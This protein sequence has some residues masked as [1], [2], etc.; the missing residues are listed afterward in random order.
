[1]KELRIIIAGSRN[2]NDYLL[3][4]KTVF[5]I[6][7]TINK[8]D[9]IIKIISGGAKGAD[10]LGEKFA[11]NFKFDIVRFIPD[12]NKLGKRAGYVRNEQMAKYAI[13]DNS[14]GILI[15]FWDGISKGTM[16]MIN[17]A[18]KYNLE[19]YIIR[20]DTGNLEYIREN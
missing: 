14:K 9:N 12:W 18:K 11:K 3:L 13:Q 8:S 20:Y 15:A 16:H 2:F 19:I 17:L 5:N 1:M 4:E 7:N 6:V 10:S